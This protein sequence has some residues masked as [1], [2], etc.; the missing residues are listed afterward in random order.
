MRDKTDP[1]SLL[2]PSSEDFIIVSGK[3]NEDSIRPSRTGIYHLESGWL[4]HLTVFALKTGIKEPTPGLA[5]EG[6]RTAW[7]SVV[8]E[9]YVPWNFIVIR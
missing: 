1:V 4:Y 8:K 5:V 7:Q 9:T 3:E 6:I 2:L